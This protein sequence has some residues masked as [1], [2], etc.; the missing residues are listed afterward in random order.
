MIAQ[1]PYVPPVPADIAGLFQEQGFE[2]F[3]IA[4]AL[5]SPEQEEEYRTWLAAGHAGSMAWLERHAPLKFHPERI[6]P[7]CRSVLVA[8]VNYYQR[9]SRAPAGGEGRVARYAWGRDYHRVLG[10]RLRKIVRVL[11]ERFPEDRFRAFT[12]A[13]PL[14]ERFYAELAGVGFTGRNTLLISA[15]Y[16]SWLL[17]GEILSTR[18]FP[19]SGPAGMGHGA[20]PGGCRKCIAVCPTGA[21]LGPHKIDA[22]RCISYLTIE[23]Q[24][25]IPE[26]LRPKMG[27]WLFGCDLCQEVCPLNVRAQVTGE[28]DFV[29]V[30]AGETVGLRSILEMRDEEEARARFAG[31]PLLRAGRRGLVRNACVVAANNGA[32]EL[33]PVLQR[34]A[35]DP[36]PVV[37]EHAAWAVKRLAGPRPAR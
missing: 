18:G 25:S 16:G 32:R 33:L 5:A 26:E 27:N 13:A 20:C 14:A 34:L 1:K 22:A 17:I 9:P 31:S 8:G 23:H 19:P 2:L 3:G 35:R 6:L 11:R 10:K 24:G 15:Q 37:A 12:D 28:T 29:R 30:K 7:G 21:L 4:Q 36:D